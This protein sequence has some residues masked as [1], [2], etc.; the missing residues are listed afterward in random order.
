VAPKRE[1]LQGC[2]NVGGEIAALVCHCVECPGTFPLLGWLVQLLAAA[3][4]FHDFAALT[5]TFNLGPLREPPFSA[6]VFGIHVSE[7]YC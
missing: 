5:L 1:L 3:Y 6:G 2:E 4:T 7:F